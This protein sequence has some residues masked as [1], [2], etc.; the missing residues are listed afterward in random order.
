M[1]ESPASVVVTYKVTVEPAGWEYVVPWASTIEPV[2]ADADEARLTRMLAMVPVSVLPPPSIKIVSPTS[3]PTVDSTD[4]IVP[5][6]AV[7][8][9]NVVAPGA[10]VRGVVGA[11]VGYDVVGLDVG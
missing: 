4:K 6:A 8:D 9:V 5:P 1:A 7:A 3:K 2:L 10:I 11:G